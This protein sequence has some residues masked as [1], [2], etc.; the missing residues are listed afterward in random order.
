MIQSIGR[1]LIKTKFTGHSPLKVCWTSCV[2]QSYLPIRSYVPLIKFRGNR[3]LGGAGPEDSSS[4]NSSSQ[5]SEDQLQGPF[6]FWDVPEKFGNIRLSEEDMNMYIQGA[7]DDVP[8][9]EN[10]IL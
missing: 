6:E 5:G 1:N 4:L 8:N 10:I 9:W 7:N 3:L 2:M